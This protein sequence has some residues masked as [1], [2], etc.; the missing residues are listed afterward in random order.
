M[1]MDFGCDYLKELEVGSNAHNRNQVNFLQIV[2]VIED[3]QLSELAH[4]SAYTDICASVKKQLVLVAQ[5]LKETE[6]KTAF[7]H[8]EYL[9]DGTANT[10]TDA[11]LSIVL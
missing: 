11:I 1:A 9:V 2:T 5:Y 6:M 4:I 3:G 10:I 8:I 7:I